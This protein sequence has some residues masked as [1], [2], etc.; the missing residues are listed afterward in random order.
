MK[1][2]IIAAL[3][4]GVIT[5]LFLG[6]T[7]AGR[8]GASAMGKD[9]LKGA[10]EAIDPSD[11]SH[12]QLMIGGG[13]GGT[14]HVTWVEDYWTGCG[15][16]PGIGIGTGSMDGA[17]DETLL[18]IDLLLRFPTTNQTFEFDL[19]FTY[20]EADDTLSGSGAIWHRVGAD[21]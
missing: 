3:V 20:S 10:W 12:M 5:G 13:P 19:A 9:P 7:S 4:V 6:V 1:R 14:Y 17:N 18:H 15:G 16:E 11:N 2:F 21:I 8:A